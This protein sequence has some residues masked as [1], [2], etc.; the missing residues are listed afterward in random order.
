[1]RVS[2]LWVETREGTRCVRVVCYISARRTQ[3][4]SD[5]AQSDNE[6]MDEQQGRAGSSQLKVR[7][8]FI[9]LEQQFAGTERICSGSLVMHRVLLPLTEGI[10]IL[11]WARETARQ[12]SI[13][14]RPSM[15]IMWRLCLH[16]FSAQDA[17]QVYMQDH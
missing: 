6:F 8:I 9:S 4:P 13:R 7:E 17:L 14:E 15:L 5:D 3:Y 2:G 12:Y 16:S 11:P 1:M 10:T